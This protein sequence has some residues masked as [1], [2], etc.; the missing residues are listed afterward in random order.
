MCFLSKT[1]LIQ[2]IPPLPAH[3]LVLKNVFPV[4]GKCFDVFFYG[5][6]SFYQLLLATQAPCRLK[7]A[8]IWGA[9]RLSVF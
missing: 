6:I 1:A 8:G 7:R 2:T 3:R 5:M 4:N 9:V